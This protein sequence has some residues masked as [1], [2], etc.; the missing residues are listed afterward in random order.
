MVHQKEPTTK[1][2]GSFL[3]V[4]TV[5]NREDG[6]IPIMSAFF[7]FPVFQH[8]N[9]QKSGHC[10]QRQRRTDVTGVG[11]F[12]FP[13]IPTIEWSEKRKRIL[14]RQGGRATKAIHSIPIHHHLLPKMVQLAVQTVT[15]NSVTWLLEIC[16][17]PIRAREVCT[18]IWYKP[19]RRCNDKYYSFRC[20]SYIS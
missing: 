16:Q 7:L 17:I 14:C 11:P 20:C 2:A 18:K 4:V 15:A 13:S 9:G 12:S 3:F 19:Q 10:V 5:Y 1:V 8:L 6:L